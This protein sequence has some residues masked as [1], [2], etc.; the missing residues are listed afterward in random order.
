MRLLWL[1]GQLFIVIA[2]GAVLIIAVI[3]IWYA[4]S[5]AVL[6]VM[7]RLLPLRGRKAR[8]ENE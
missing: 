5:F 8:N 6:T 1:L 4:F 2:W 7:G 3:G